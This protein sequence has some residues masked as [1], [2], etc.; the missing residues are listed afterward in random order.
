MVELDRGSVLDEILPHRFQFHNRRG[1]PIISHFGVR[2]VRPACIV[3]CHQCSTHNSQR[4]QSCQ[5][6][7]PSAHPCCLPQCILAQLGCLFGKV[8]GMIQAQDIQSGPQ[9]CTVRCHCHGKVRCQ[10]NRLHPNFMSIITAIITQSRFYH[11]PTDKALRATH[12]QQSN[13]ASLVSLRNASAHRE[14]HPRQ[15]ENETHSASQH[16]M[17]VLP[18]V[19]EFEVRQRHRLALLPFGKRLVP[20][21][22]CHPRI[23]RHGR[24]GTQRTPIGH[25]QSGLGQSGDTTNMDHPDNGTCRSQNPLADWRVDI[26]RRLR[27]QRESCL[28]QAGGLGRHLISIRLD[29]L[30]LYDTM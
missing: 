15:A 20:L 6:D 7:A 14:V 21:E 22:F 3:A 13:H 8:L 2:V 30:C 28:Q 19:N 25:G 11:P 26:L 23:L 5:V 17:P 16:P 10:P 24:Q 1:D 9:Q 18:T 27:R 29:Y 12:S 4:R